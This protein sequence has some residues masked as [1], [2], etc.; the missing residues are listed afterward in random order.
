[1]DHLPISASI[2]ADLVSIL[3]PKICQHLYT[4]CACS[5]ILYATITLVIHN[6]RSFLMTLYPYMI[7]W[8]YISTT[9]IS[10]LLLLLYPVFLICCVTLWN[11][12]LLLI[13]FGKLDF[14]GQIIIKPFHSRQS[15]KL[16]G[17]CREVCCCIYLLFYGGFPESAL[18]LNHFSIL[19]L[20]MYFSIFS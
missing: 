3:K 14:G 5:A 9:F 18:C 4:F 7:P 19:S 10:F 15:L 20:I 2:C 12:F 11:S 17:R 6:Q 1:M 13:L 8:T 16:S